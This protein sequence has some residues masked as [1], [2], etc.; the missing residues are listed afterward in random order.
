MDKDLT[1][2]PQAQD[3]PKPKDT[4]HRPVI[5]TPAQ[6]KLPRILWYSNAIHVP[7]G[8]GQQTGLIVPRLQAQGF[9]TAIQCNVGVEGAMLEIGGVPHYPRDPNLDQDRYSVK[10]IGPAASHHGAD[11]T[12]TFLD[13]WALDARHFGQTSLPVAMFPVDSQPLPRPVQY[14]ASTFWDRITYSRH[15]WDMCNDAGLDSHYIPHGINTSV[16]CPGD[17]LEARKREK[18]GILPNGEADPDLFIIGCVAAN[19]DRRPSRKGW[20]NIF[21]GV[22]MFRDRHPLGPKTRLFIHSRI[23]GAIQL[24]IEAQCNG[25]DDI[26]EVVN[27]NRIELGLKT[28]AMADI[29][30]AMDVLVSVGNEGFGLPIVEAQ[31]CATPVIV[32]DWGAASELGFS[33]IRIPKE[34]AWKFGIHHDP[35][36][37]WYLASP[38]AIYESLCAVADARGGSEWDAW[39][40]DAREGA[41][42]YDIDRIVQEFWVPTLISMHER[43]ESERAVVRKPRL[44]R[45]N[46]KQYTKNESDNVAQ[47]ISEMEIAPDA[48]IVSPSNGEKCGIAEYADSCAKALA[49]EG[50]Y[51]YVIERADSALAIIASLEKTLPIIVNHEYSFFDHKNPV[52]GRGE[53]TPDVLESLWQYHQKGGKVSILIHTASPRWGELAANDL[54]RRYSEMGLPIFTTS[55][56]GAQIVGARWMPLGAWDVPGAAPL[57]EVVE[58]NTQFVIGNF[59]FATGQRDYGKHIALC[60]ATKSVFMGS[61]ACQSLS[62]A[63]KL[64]TIL[65]ESGITDPILYTDFA[66]EQELMR[67]L[68]RVDVFYMPRIEDELKSRSASVVTAMNAH[69]PVIV[70]KH[71]CYR[72]LW[73][74]LIV[75]DTVEEAAVII[76]RLRDPAEYRAAV[77][78]IKEYLTRRNVA[79]VWKEYGVI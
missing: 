5:A 30:R 55:F 79:N 23:E 61:F 28:E 78:R 53:E 18:I 52:L 14:G 65:I 51:A 22:R 39:Q 20:E 50:L 29:Y 31:A 68:S 26:T 45:D 34:R 11:L 41:Q 54:L 69:R 2:A 6:K 42:A 48:F 13:V 40:K 27:Q 56:K 37:F 25:I 32:G 70:N 77:E 58:P 43:G 21:T 24:E 64:K 19:N 16:Y 1:D 66:D 38:E 12:I 17:R 57:P 59:G 8:Y 62:I 63:Q 35:T 76:E 10:R 33:G 73:D 15:G 67:R 60:H 7:S 49:A 71:E 3:R 74:T 47:G 72:D 46:P 75:A 9:D 36:S 44:A 4:H